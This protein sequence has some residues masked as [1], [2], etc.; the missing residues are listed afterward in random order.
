M[1]SGFFFL[2]LGWRIGVGVG[3]GS[4]VAGI[5]GKERAYLSSDL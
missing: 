1:F 5:E 4:G 3:G 2:D